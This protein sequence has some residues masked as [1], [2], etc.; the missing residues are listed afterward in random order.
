M[1]L[2]LADIFENM[3]LPIAKNMPIICRIAISGSCEQLNGVEL[4]FREAKSTVVQNVNSSVSA[5]TP[6][7]TATAQSVNMNEQR[8]G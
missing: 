2:E 5:I 1:G 8:H 4:K 6:A 7:A 3:G